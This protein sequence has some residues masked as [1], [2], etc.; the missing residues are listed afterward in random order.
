MFSSPSAAATR[1]RRRSCRV[2]A[3]AVGPG[4]ALLG[5]CGAPT[6]HTAAA[7]PPVTQPTAHRSG[8]DVR[9]RALGDLPAPPRGHRLSVGVADGVVPDGVTV[10]DETH[11]AVTRLDPDLLAALRAAGRAAGSDGVRLDVHSGWRSRR[12][13]EELFDE[14]VEEYGSEAEAAAWVARPGTSAHEAGDAVDL[15]PDEADRWLSTHGAA[16]GL[17]QVYRNEPWHFELRPQAV[18]DGCPAMYADPTE[19]P[20]MRR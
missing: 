2:V 17:C 5:G 1:R 14:A 10:F 19:D 13:Q 7:P 3:L 16:Y 12:Y 20:R 15:G 8:E 18:D 6:G 11:P 9:P 4:L